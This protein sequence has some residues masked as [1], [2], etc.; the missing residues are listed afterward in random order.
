MAN[1]LVPESLTMVLA[2][3]QARV[4]LTDQEFF[5]WCFNDY[6]SINHGAFQ[7]TLERSDGSGIGCA[8]V[9]H[10]PGRSLFLS[11]AEITQ[12]PSAAG[13]AREFLL[14]C[15]VRRYRLDFGGTKRVTLE[16]W[17][18]HQTAPDL[19]GSE[20]YQIHWENGGYL[21]KQ[22]RLAIGLQTLDKKLIPANLDYAGI[23]HLRHEAKEKLSAFRPQ[24]LGQANRISGITPADIIVIQVHLKKYYD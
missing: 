13:S 4:R 7:V 2:G 5:F 15:E 12:G 24:T 16:E 1:E 3:V 8:G 19:M 17:H 21:A 23:T 14:D 20:S 18:Y 11:L 10:S 22:E 6:L 9:V